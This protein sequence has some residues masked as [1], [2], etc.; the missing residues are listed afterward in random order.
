MRNVSYYII[1]HAAK[2][3]P[4]DSV[5]INTNI[6]GNINNVAFKTPK[7][8][9]VIIAQNDNN[10]TESFNIK[11]KQRSALATLPAGAVGTFLLN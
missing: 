10:K 6:T 2:F 9:I 1:A 5:R 8:A 4:P 7:G 3:V 11:F